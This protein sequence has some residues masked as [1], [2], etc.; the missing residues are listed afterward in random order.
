MNRLLFQRGIPESVADISARTALPV[1]VPRTTSHDSVS[2]EP[3]AGFLYTALGGSDS[4][5]SDRFTG[6][7][8]AKPE[9]WPQAC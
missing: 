5:P 4:R 2:W 9:W 8:S 6:V 3:Q 7:T 1:Q